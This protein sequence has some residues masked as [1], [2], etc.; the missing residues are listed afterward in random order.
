M[1]ICLG[2]IHEL[3]EGDLKSFKVGRSS[4]MQLDNAIGL[5]STS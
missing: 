4:V 2:P 5:T 3:S 1:M